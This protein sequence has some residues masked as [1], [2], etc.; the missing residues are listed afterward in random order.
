MDNTHEAEEEEFS[1]NLSSMQ[2][3]ATKRDVEH[4][5]EEFSKGN[6]SMDD[7]YNVTSELARE[8][9]EVN[10]DKPEVY[11][12]SRG[13]TLGTHILSTPKI[14]LAAS[15]VPLLNRV[16]TLACSVYETISLP[17]SKVSY[18]SFKIAGKILPI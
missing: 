3:E 14:F 15:I 7:Y 13:A 6:I 2:G 12:W 1:P 8:G 18:S 4:L 9:L 17:E 10:T 11:S 5:K 16:E